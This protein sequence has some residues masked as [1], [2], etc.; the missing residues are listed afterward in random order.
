MWAKTISSLLLG[1]FLTVSLF[2]NLVQAGFLPQ[3]V[4]ILIGFV[5]GFFVWG[6]VMT[7]FYTLHSI[8]KPLIYSTL[9]LLVSAGLNAL[10][11]LEVI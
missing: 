5:G 8:K 9:I 10:F 6:G 3:D 7:Y 4:S 2:T 1:F 11:I